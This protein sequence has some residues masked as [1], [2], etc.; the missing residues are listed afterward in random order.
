VNQSFTVLGGAQTITFD[1]I[2][3]QLR[4]TQLDLVATASSGLT[5]GFAS[6]TPP[7]CTVSGTVASLIY[8]GECIIHASQ[9]GNSAYSAAPPVYRSFRV[10][11][12][13]TITFNP[14]ADHRKGG[15]VELDAT[16]SSHLRVGY[17]SLTTDVC[18]VSGRVATLNNT[19]TC[20]IQASQPGDRDFFPAQPVSQSFTVLPDR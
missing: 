13:Q 12:D 20:T 4:G 14:I 6:L 19:G 7:I 3:D 15:T 16:A 9:P 17:E 1:K 8:P 5:V 11:D 18:T 10:K 2:P